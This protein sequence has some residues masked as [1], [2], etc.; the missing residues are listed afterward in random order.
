LIKAGTTDDAHA[1]PAAPLSRTW[2]VVEGLLDRVKGSDEPDTDPMTHAINTTKGR[3]LEALFNHALRECRLADKSKG[4]HATEWAR[5]KPV[6]DK[7]LAKCEADNLEFSTLAGAYIGNLDYLDSSWARDN[8]ARIF[9]LEREANFSSA[10]GGLAYS[11]PTRRHYVMLR[12][13]G[14]L[15]RALRLNLKGRDTRKELIE[16]IGLGYLWGEETL[17]SPRLEYMF[18]GERVEDLEAAAW[19]FWTVRDEKLSEEQFARDIAFWDKCVTFSAAL[20]KPPAKLM[21]AL[22]NLAWALPNAAGRTANC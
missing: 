9:P 17:H 1:Y 12:D 10:L 16:R 2:S 11:Q 14:I 19:F 4:E 15:D 18:D 21:A 8:F 7:E 5:M 13:A 20:S 6:F 22:G 3:V